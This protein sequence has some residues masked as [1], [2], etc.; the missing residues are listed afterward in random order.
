MT[1]D[2]R[3]REPVYG[4]EAAGEGWGLR[5]LP[6]HLRVDL[7]WNGKLGPRYEVERSAAPDGPW[8][9]LDDGRRNAPVFSDFIGEAGKA[10]YYRVRRQVEKRRFSEWSPPVR[11]VSSRARTRDELLTEVQEAAFRYFWHGGHPTSGIALEGIPRGTNLGAS[12]ATGMG[13]FTLVVGIERGFVPRRSC[14]KRVLKILRFLGEKAERFHGAFSHWLNANT[15]KVIP[16]GKNDDEADIVET[17]YLA[18]GLIFL[19]EYFTRNTEDEADIRRLA[20][21]LWRDIEWDWF[22]RK[23]DRGPYLKWHSAETMRMGVHGFNECQIVYLLALCSP[24]HPVRPEV[25]WKGWE[26][27]RD[28]KP[29]EHFGVTNE[30]GKGMGGPLFFTHYSYMG[31]DPKTIHFR[32]KTYFEQFRNLALIQARYAESRRNDFKGYG[33]L[34]GLTASH[35]PKGYKAHAPGRRDDGTITPTA[36][37]SSI[38]YAPEEGISC[39][40]EMYEK[41]GARLWGEFGFYDAFNFTVDWVSPGFL[42]IDQG[43]IAPMIENHR[44]GFCWKTFMKAPEIAR[45]VEMLAERNRPE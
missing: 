7:V 14:A 27:Y 15:G 11:G 24:T 44:T 1:P 6:R 45:V 12:G 40:V 42:G 4:G 38:P 29:R 37:L 21:K 30:L 5:A 32:G 2:G 17:A 22:E 35:N 39:L 28:V 19:R 36:A 34:W 41:H 31:F 18:E 8:K 25:Y 33:P 16:F 13:L 3:Y 26:R 23:S 10:F 20:D 9:R 43:P